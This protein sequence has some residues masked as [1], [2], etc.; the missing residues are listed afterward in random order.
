MANHIMRLVLAALIC[1]PALVLGP[2]SAAAQGKIEFGITSY[3]ANTISHFIAD[4]KKFYQAEKLSVETIVAGSAANVIQQLGGGSLQI[5]QAATNQTL[6]AIIQ[7]AP[8]VIVSG[9]LSAAPFRVVSAKTISKWDQLKGKTISV[10][11]PTDQTLYFLRVMAGKNGLNDKDYDLIYAG[12]T[13]D[14][15][16]HL[17]SGAAAATV[18]TNPLDFTALDQGYVDLGAVPQYLPNWAQNNVQINRTW[19]QS[20]RADV[21]AFLRAFVKATDF[22]YDPSHRDEVIDILAKYTKSDR[23][24]AEKT[25]DFYIDIKAVPAHG[26]LFTAGIQ[27]NL[28]AFVDMGEMK[29]TPPVAN[30][31]DPSYLAEATR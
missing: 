9:A 13:P 19:G 26:A 3:T 11:G 30:F 14:R 15:L 29:T 10:G 22:F 18:L 7:G 24:S 17:I 12:G 23:T 1:A 31:I 25:Y 2:G 21:V 27:A 20:H 5:A 16:A 4:D 6:R 8:I 28:D